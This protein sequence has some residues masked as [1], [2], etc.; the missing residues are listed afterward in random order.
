MENCANLVFMHYNVSKPV[1]NVMSLEGC[2]SRY[3]I[4]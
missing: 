3:D 4:R 1:F 2:V